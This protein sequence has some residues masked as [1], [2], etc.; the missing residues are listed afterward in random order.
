VDELEK[1]R[2]LRF[3]PCFIGL[4][5]ATENEEKGFDADECFNP[6]FI[7]LASATRI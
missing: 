1:D 4:A 5:S 3:N 7:G 2:G 6:C